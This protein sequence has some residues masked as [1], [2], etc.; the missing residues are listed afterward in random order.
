MDTSQVLNPEA[1][2]GNFNLLKTGTIFL[3][4]LIPFEMICVSEITMN[5][6]N[7]LNVLFDFIRRA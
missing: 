2:N 7:T 6:N 4:S 3:L 1:H 5:E